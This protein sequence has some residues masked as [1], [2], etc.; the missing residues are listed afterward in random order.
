M[1]KKERENYLIT[2]DILMI[3]F[4]DRC[5]C[6]HMYTHPHYKRE[7]LGGKDVFLNWALNP[8]HPLKC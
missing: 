7:M 6:R 1:Y 5:L 4:L 2:L 8:A 3:F